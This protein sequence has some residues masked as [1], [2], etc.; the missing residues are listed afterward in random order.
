M[1]YNDVWNRSELYNPLTENCTT[2]GNLAYERFRHAASTLKDGRVLVTGGYPYKN[3]II[4][5]SLYL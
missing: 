5:Y 4:L 2:T 3:L 1:F